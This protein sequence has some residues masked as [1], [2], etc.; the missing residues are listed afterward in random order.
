M[1]KILASIPKNMIAFLSIV[2]GIL[3]IIFIVSPPKTVCDA[4]IELIQKSQAKFLYKNPKS[5][6]V[7]TTKYQSRLEFCR[8][9]NN[10]G[11]CYELFHDMRNFLVDLSNVPHECNSSVGAIKEFDKAMWDSMT[12]IVQLA[13]GDKPPTAYNAK[14]GWLDTADL[15]LYCQLK[16]RLQIIYGETRWDNYREKT[17]NELPGAK[18]L[19]RNQKWDMSIFSEN[20]ARYPW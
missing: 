11:A 19:G 20:C 16:N 14:F 12:L 4:Q 5:K 15:T 17:M 10:P 6:M 18:E 13:W 3:F 8:S 2:S 9:R 7:K 1:D